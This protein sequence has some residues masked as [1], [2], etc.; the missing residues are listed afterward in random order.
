MDYSRRKL[1][2]VFTALARG[3]I[4][5]FLLPPELVTAAISPASGVNESSLQPVSAKMKQ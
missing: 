5:R 4:R 3:T 1:I 2:Q